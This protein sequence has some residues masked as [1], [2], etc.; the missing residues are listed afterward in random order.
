MYQHIVVEVLS[1]WFSLVKLFIRAVSTALGETVHMTR[2][3]HQRRPLIRFSQ[4]LN[5]STDFSCTLSFL[6]Q[7]QISS[8]H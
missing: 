5:I 4:L 2:C 7:P 8:L 6:R 1:L 3:S